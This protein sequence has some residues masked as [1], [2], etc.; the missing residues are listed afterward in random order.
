MLIGLLPVRT[1]RDP[2]QRH[3]TAQIVRTPAAP[4]GRPAMTTAVVTDRLR[5]PST[6][7]SEETVNL[8]RMAAVILSSVALAAGGVAATASSAAAVGGCPSGKLCLYED[9]YFIDLDV[10]STSTKAC[11]FLGNR[12]ETGFFDGIGSYVN[13]LPVNAVVYHYNGDK[14]LFYLDGT[15][16]PGG[17]SSNS[18]TLAQFGERGAVCTGGVDPNAGL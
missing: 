13:N 12:G 18:R 8:K 4:L 1:G 2:D 6:R 3:I 10:T 17:S 11:I 16:R 5:T 9:A 7:I 15:I 14:K